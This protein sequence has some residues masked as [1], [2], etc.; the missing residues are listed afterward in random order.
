MLGVEYRERERERERDGHRYRHRH[1]H[2]HRQ[3]NKHNNYFDTL[4]HGM[5]LRGEG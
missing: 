5:L 2:R 4:H 3:T 1:R